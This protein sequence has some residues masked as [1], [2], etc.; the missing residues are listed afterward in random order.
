MPT[1]ARLILLYKIIH[2]VFRFVLRVYMI[3]LITCRMAVAL[4]I[5]EQK[6]H[7]LWDFL[8]LFFAS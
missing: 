4:A 3:Y 7:I 1:F 6:E 5:C 2:V 8:R